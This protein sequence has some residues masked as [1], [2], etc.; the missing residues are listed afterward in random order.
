[1]RPG[2]QLPRPLRLGL[3]RLARRPEDVKE[4][5]AVVVDERHAAA[6]AVAVL[7]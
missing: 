3:V 6:A 7:P 1:V 4:G 5:P 2:Q